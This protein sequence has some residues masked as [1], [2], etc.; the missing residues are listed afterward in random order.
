MLKAIRRAERRDQIDT[1]R[2][3]RAILQN[4]LHQAH[5]DRKLVAQIAAAVL[6]ITPEQVTAIIHRGG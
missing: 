4:E 6:K 5:V 3:I 2:R 1:I